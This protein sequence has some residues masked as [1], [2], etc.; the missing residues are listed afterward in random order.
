MTARKDDGAEFLEKQ[1]REEMSLLMLPPRRKPTAEELHHTVRLLLLTRSRQERAI[2][3]LHV[4]HGRTLEQ[5]GAHLSLP[6][7]RVRDFYRSMCVREGRARQWLETQTRL[8]R[9]EG[10]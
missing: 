2:V 10:R 6:L 1:L 8:A 9:L 7:G 5:V 3:C 4:Y